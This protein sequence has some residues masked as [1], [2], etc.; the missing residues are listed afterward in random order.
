MS[1]LLIIFFLIFSIN[2]VDIN[3]IRYEVD[4]GIMGLGRD[5]CMKLINKVKTEDKIKSVFY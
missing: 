5:V 1:L 2:L 3:M 4:N